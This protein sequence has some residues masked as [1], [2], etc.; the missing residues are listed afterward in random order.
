VL[1]TCEELGRRGDPG[2]ARKRLLDFARSAPGAPLLAERQLAIAATYEEE[3]KWAEAIAQYDSWLASF[4]N[5]AAR[6]RAEYYRASDTYQAGRETN[7]LALLTNFVARFPTN[8]FAPLAQMSVADHYYNARDFTEAERNYKLLFQNTNWAPSTLSYEAQ[9]MAGRAAAGHQGWKDAGEYFKGLYNDKACP[10]DLRVQALFEY[11]QTLLR[12]VDPTDPNKLANI[13]EATRV[14]GRI[15]EEFPTHWL[16]VRAWMERANCYMQWALIKQQADSLTNAISAYQRVIDSAQ[17]DVAARSEAKVGQAIA[18]SKWAEQKAGAEQTA[19]LRQALSNCLDV[20]YGTILRD[21]EQPD[22]FMTKKAG[23]QAFD[24][25]ES[26]QAWSQAVG[27]YQRL[28]N[29]IWPQLPASLEKRAAR[30]RE[31]LE[32]EKANN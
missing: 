9:L 6:P 15:C 10:N 4:T 29:N 30:A 8:E 16:A 13:E 17:A 11:G 3:K 19:L 20:V 32:K 2:A 5:H 23:M 1:L 18:L 21:G 14:F 28:T 24:L 27:L 7:A 26:L 12:M 22:P 31:N 25:A